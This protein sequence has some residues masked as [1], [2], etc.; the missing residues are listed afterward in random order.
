MCVKKSI[1]VEFLWHI[2]FLIFFLTFAKVS[3]ILFKPPWLQCSNR[4]HI[5]SLRHQSEVTEAKGDLG[6][7]G[8][9][10]GASNEIFNHWRWRELRRQHHASPVLPPPEIHAPSHLSNLCSQICYTRELLTSQPNVCDRAAFESLPLPF[11]LPHFLSFPCSWGKKT[12]W[13][14][15]GWGIYMTL[16]LVEL[17]G[18]SL[19]GGTALAAAG[20]FPLGCVRLMHALGFW[21]AEVVGDLFGH[22]HTVRDSCRAF[23]NGTRN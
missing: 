11:S 4:S 1:I 10:L 20:F 5:S 9:G 12:G 13:E 3:Q 15:R 14:E 17:L 22:V 19:L 23:Y 6:M 2:C 7:S 21:G 8:T 18:H 16:E